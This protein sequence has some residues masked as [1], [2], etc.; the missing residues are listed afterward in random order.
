[1]VRDLR[2]KNINALGWGTHLVRFLKELLTRDISPKARRERYDRLVKAEKKKYSKWKSD[3]PS[4]WN[5]KKD[6]PTKDH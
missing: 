6:G 2:G 5:I 3:Y 1:M 4:D